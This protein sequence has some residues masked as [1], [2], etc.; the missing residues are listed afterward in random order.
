MLYYTYNYLEILLSTKRTFLTFKL[1]L[2]A[3]FLSLLVRNFNMKA[4]DHLQISDQKSLQKSVLIFY[5]LC[6][7]LFTRFV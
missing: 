1:L 7:L 5:A 3:Y 4:K 6:F 2:N